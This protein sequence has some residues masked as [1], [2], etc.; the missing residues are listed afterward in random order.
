VI[1]VDA[2]ALVEWL[3]ETSTGPA[4]AREMAEHAPAHSP[5]FVHL[6]VLSA[7]RNAE[8][9]RK[10]APDRAEQAVS[11]LAATP[12]HLHRTAPFTPRIWSLRKAQTPYDAVYLALAEALGAPLLTA[13]RRLARSPGHRAT[14]V[15]AGA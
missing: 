13:D 1:V 3:L 5:D 12:L 10:L 7:L 11:D 2:S 15:S 14:I 6:E 8:A 4:V 9:A